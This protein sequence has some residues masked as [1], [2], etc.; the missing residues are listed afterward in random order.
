MK[1]KFLFFFIWVLG[2][3]CLDW[4]N[5]PLCAQG[6]GSSWSSVGYTLYRPDG[7]AYLQVAMEDLPEKMLWENASLACA[8]LGNGWRLPT[9]N[10]LDMMYRQL[11]KHGKGNFK[12]YWYWSKSQYVMHMHFGSGFVSND[13][14]SQFNEFNVRAVRNIPR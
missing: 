4:G 3:F 14:Y 13:F 9:R 5:K 10:E 8:A 6:L 7:K 12:P 1:K 11:H 2:S